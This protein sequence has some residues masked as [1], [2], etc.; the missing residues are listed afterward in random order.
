LFIVGSGG[1]INPDLERVLP[2]EMEKKYLE[3]EYSLLSSEAIPTL[4]RVE[5]L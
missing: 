2:E 5:R 4:M 3:V 1:K